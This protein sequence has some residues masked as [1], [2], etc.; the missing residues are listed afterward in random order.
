[1]LRIDRQ[2][3]IF[4]HAVKRS[5]PLTKKNYLM[6][7]L[8][9]IPKRRQT[10]KRYFASLHSNAAMPPV[11]KPGPSSSRVTIFEPND[12]RVVVVISRDRV[13]RGRL[14]LWLAQ[15]QFETLT[16]TDE[17]N[18]LSLLQN[19]QQTPI[20]VIIDRSSDDRR[21]SMRGTIDPITGNRVDY[22]SNS[23]EHSSV[24]HSN[25]EFFPDKQEM[26]SAGYE[27]TDTK[28][29][30]NG[31]SSFPL[32]TRYPLLPILTLERLERK[33]LR[34]RALQQDSIPVDIAIKRKDFKG[35]MGEILTWSN[36]AA[37]A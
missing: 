3:H 1:M 11:E 22:R 5:P 7:R 19:L 21:F 32:F 9:L 33:D 34:R 35:L 2:S 31:V 4:A 30:T 8:K 37:N 12:N 16:A 20:C 28:S 14:R 25:L 27:D 17:K 23:Q 15:M 29:E 6:K 36:T 24:K 26:V 18:A 13:I 10:K